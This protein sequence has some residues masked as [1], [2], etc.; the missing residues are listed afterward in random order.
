MRLG[1]GRPSVA[2]AST[3]KGAGCSLF[4]REPERYHCARLTEEEFRRALED[5]S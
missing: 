5:L 4:E 2:V 3:S 1:R